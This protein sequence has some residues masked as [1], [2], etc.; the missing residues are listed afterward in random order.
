[1]QLLS[2]G[3][4]GLMKLWT[5]KTSV[6]VNTFDHH[7][8][9][10]WALAVAPSDDTMVVTGGADSVINMWDDKTAEME[11]TSRQESEEKLLLEQDLANALRAK[12]YRRAAML[13]FQLK[14]PFRLLRVVQDVLQL[15]D[16]TALAQ[17]V[18]SFTPDQLNTCLLY[19]RDWNT[20]ARNAPAA[21]ALLL[22]LLQS[23]RVEELC[24]CSD[25]KAVVEALVPYTERHFE[26]LEEALQRTY[27]LD[28]T[29]HAMRDA[30]GADD[31]ADDDAEMLAWGIDTAGALAVR[32]EGEE[33]EEE[34]ERVKVQ[35][36][37]ERV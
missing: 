17:L 35:E 14:Q 28:F 32:S 30:L 4:D 20:T 6:C 21:Q 2:T 29:L 23:F 15:E 27:A 33:E 31:G 19:L 12:D 5:I 37:E 18:T 10:V 13:A 26:R 25:I 36:V 24:K 9:K 34:E 16:K 3:S 11:E 1:M 22:A 7:T 8:D